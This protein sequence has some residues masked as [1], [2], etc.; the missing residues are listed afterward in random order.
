MLIK[1]FHIFILVFW[2]DLCC[3]VND[4]GIIFEERWIKEFRSSSYLCKCMSMWA[5]KWFFF[6]FSAFLYNFLSTPYH[7]QSSLVSL[8]LSTSEAQWSTTS[9]YRPSITT[10]LPPPIFFLIDDRWA[11]AGHHI[12][13]RSSSGLSSNLPL[14]LRRLLI[15]HWSVPQRIK[16]FLGL[17]NLLSPAEIMIFIPRT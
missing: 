13:A 12:P 14:F 10:T 15:C 9:L 16:T 3:L 5:S 7:P 6:L 4:I 17:L 2:N 1:A 8:A 11:L